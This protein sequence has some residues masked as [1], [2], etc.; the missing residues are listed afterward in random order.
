MN[1][2]SVVRGRPVIGRHRVPASG[3]Q[4]S[5]AGLAEVAIVDDHSIWKRLPNLPLEVDITRCVPR[6]HADNVC[7]SSRAP[8]RNCG[9]R[10][11]SARLHKMSLRSGIT[12]PKDPRTPSLLCL[13]GHFPRHP[14]R[15]SRS[16][17]SHMNTSTRKASGGRWS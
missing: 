17:S 12:P 9:R 5:D 6:T 10:S 8:A 14:T 15:R 13:G 16:H 7:P 1:I 3:I 2:F 11:H 4:L